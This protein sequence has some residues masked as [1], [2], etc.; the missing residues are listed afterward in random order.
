MFKLFLI[1][2]FH[3]SQKNILKFVLKYF[4]T[5][6]TTWTIQT[7][8]TIPI[9]VTHNIARW[10]QTLSKKSGF[11]D[12]PAAHTFF[13][14]VPKNTFFLVQCYFSNPTIWKPTAPSFQNTL[15]FAQY[16]FNSRSNM[17]LNIVHW[18]S[19]HSKNAILP[20]FSRQTPHFLGENHKTRTHYHCGHLEPK[21][22][23]PI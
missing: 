15:T 17:R 20:T 4:L 9:L 18:N 5:K 12:N 6:I 22:G 2:I 19:L 1:S 23:C 21:G 3:N 16:L 7:R 8:R 13:I 10:K 11:P 14:K